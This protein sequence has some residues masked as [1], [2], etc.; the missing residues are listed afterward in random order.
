M[1]Y[2][3]TKCLCPWQ[4]PKAHIGAIIDRVREKVR[5]QYKDFVA[6]Y[7]LHVHHTTNDAGENVSTMCFDTLRTALIDV[8]GDEIT[9]HEIVTVARYFSA[10]HKVETHCNRDLIRSVVHLELTRGLW[11]DLDRLQEHLYHIDPRNTGYMSET[12]LRSAIVAC[13]IPLKASLV[14]FMF[15]M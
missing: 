13:R 6:K 5:G 1:K 4:F 7:L 14:G 12:K 2:L 15:S 8:F 10:E 11:D 9:E 3:V